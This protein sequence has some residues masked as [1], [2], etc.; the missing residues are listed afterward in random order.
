MDA[1]KIMIMEAQFLL[2]AILQKIILRATVHYLSMFGFAAIKL[3]QGFKSSML[4]KEAQSLQ[5]KVV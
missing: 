4:K 2:K 5:I 3:I 1:L